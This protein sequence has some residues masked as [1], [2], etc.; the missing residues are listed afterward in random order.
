MYDVTYPA[1][2]DTH[3]VYEHRVRGVGSAAVH[4]CY[5]VIK[6]SGLITR[7]FKSSGIWRRVDR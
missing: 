4:R 1:L 6:L 7:K 5:V 2:P 3:L